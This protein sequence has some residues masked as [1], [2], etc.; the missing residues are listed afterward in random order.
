MSKLKKKKLDFIVMNSTRN[1]GTTFGSDDNQI[2][3][4][5]E[6]AKKTFPKKPKTE[7]AR[8]IIDELEIP[9]REQ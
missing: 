6:T 1:E 5:S 3:I 8:D 7:V 4:I 9:L 2:V